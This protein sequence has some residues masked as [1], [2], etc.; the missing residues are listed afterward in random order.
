MAAPLSY[1]QAPIPPSPT[2]KPLSKNTP[3]SKT[4]P[5]QS[6]PTLLLLEKC[7]S[8]TQLKEIHAQMLRSGLFSDAFAASRIVAFCAVEASGSLSYARLVFAQIP[9]PTPFTFNSIIRGYTNKN[10]P[11][12]AVLFYQE[13]IEGGL[14]PDN[15]T[16]P[17]L[18][19]SCGGS[20]EGKQLHCH[21]VKF[22]FAADS[23]VQNTLMNMYANCGCLS[24]ARLVFNKMTERNVVSF[25][26]IIAAY[27]NWDRPGEAV[28]LFQRMEFENVVPN[29]VALVN[30]LMACARAR[31]LDMAKWVHRYMEDNRIGFN[32]ILTA[33]L[34]DVYCKC[35]FVYVARELFDEMSDRNLFCWN[36]M[37]NGHVEDS[38]YKE[39]LVLFRE[40]QIRGVKPDKVTMAS[41]L[42][43]CSQLGALELGKWLHAYINKENIEVD[44]VLR[45][46]LVDMYA[47]CG[48]IES[49]LRVFHEMPERDVMTWTA[50]IGGLAMCGHGEKALELFYE[51][52]RSG[53][54]P[55]AIT[56]VGV[57][58]ACS[59][60]GLVDE[61][62][63][64]FDSMSSL[65]NIK[66]SVEHYGCM[67][68]LLGRAGHIE[69]AEEFIRNMP[70]V[71]DFF[72]LGGLL[73][74]CRIHGNLEVAERAARQLLELD[75]A[76]GGAY[77][78][79]SNI[80]G[81]L[82]KWD[83]VK[84]TRE[85]M[86]ERNIKKP[87]G[88]SLIEVD[89]VVHEFVMGD[90]SHPQSHEIYSMVEDMVQLLKVA[91]YVP[92]KSEVLFDMDE[93]EKEN[94]LCRHSEKLAIAFGLIST[95]PGTTIRVVKN[96]RVCNDCHTATKLIS[97]VYNREIIVR[98]R[99]R[100]HH[101]KDG[102]CSCKDFW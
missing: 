14:V 63:S 44:I 100:F 86:A 37:I 68:D 76:N 56:F 18:F 30:V 84:R 5:I 7:S 92:N 10:S 67:V 71:P 65:Y 91:G 9:N 51:M 97:K 53:V 70:M 58:S 82:G 80:Y 23:Y 75:P 39:A 38:D 49:A 12:E 83:E 45:T 64:H 52:Q 88:C 55:D 50:M 94:A 79:L 72:V 17:S 34:M 46:A 27:A 74:A 24:H 21:A 4:I 43:A 28:S 90:E 69:K 77:V 40:M 32:T 2:Q 85:L 87:P 20:D 1:L 78:L 101:F 89:G 81:S 13:I 35:G 15:F 96:L 48:S 26:T 29:E 41:L 54:R 95:S 73:G 33:A 62:F 60:A 98:D 25:A 99:N 102:S 93:E 42:L 59:H 66:P 16:F 36:I 57:L 31:D 19:K 3:N 22:G 11:E 47:K 6:H 61:G 8:M